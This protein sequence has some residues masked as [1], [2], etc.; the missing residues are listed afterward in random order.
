MHG[1]RPDLFQLRQLFLAA[2]ITVS[3]IAIIAGVAMCSGTSG[4]SPWAATFIAIAIKLGLKAQGDRFAIEFGDKTLFT[5]LDKTF[6]GAGRIALWTKADSVTRFEQIAI[7]V[8][9]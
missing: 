8:L 6:A 3:A 4:F 5:T 1:S 2:V 7:D 9:P